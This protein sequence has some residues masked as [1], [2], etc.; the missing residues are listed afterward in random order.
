MHLGRHAKQNFSRGGFLWA[1]TLLLAVGNVVVHGR[2]ELLAQ[3]VNG[4]AMEADHR[5]NAQHPADEN[6]VAFVVLLLAA[7][8]AYIGWKFFKYTE[9]SPPPGY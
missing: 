2:H 7:G 1:H 5:A 3:L 9:W 6:V 8:L 4:F